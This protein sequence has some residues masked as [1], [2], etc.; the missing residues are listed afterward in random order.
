MS[1]AKSKVAI[2]PSFDVDDIAPQ[3][4]EGVRLLPIIHGRV[5]MGS[6]VRWVLQEVQPSGVAV[7]LPTTFT[8]VVHAAVGR[9]PS[10]SVVI[11]EEPGE[12][13][14]LWVVAPG[15]PFAEAL[16]WAQDEDRASWLVDPDIRYTHRHQEA[17]P[18]P[19]PEQHH[20]DEKNRI[21][22]K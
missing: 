15:D 19:G 21:E 12:E 4:V 7:E 8:K 11:S 6:L 1:E 20:A 14:L 22:Q 18:R 2:S 17:I 13:A 3:V 16:R 9:L 10:I 5:D